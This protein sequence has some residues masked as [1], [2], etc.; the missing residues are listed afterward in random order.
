MCKRGSFHPPRSFL[1]KL[2]LGFGISKIAK[3]VT[4][5]GTVII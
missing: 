5:T 3:Q 2:P 1:S 4:A